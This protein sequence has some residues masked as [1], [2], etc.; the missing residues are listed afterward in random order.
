MW[1][2]VVGQTRTTILL[3]GAWSRSAQA[4]LQDWLLTQYRGLPV[5]LRAAPLFADN[6]GVLGVVW[7][8]GEQTPAF[9]TLLCSRRPRVRSIAA[10]LR[11]CLYF[12]R[13]GRAGGLPQQVARAGARGAL[14]PSCAK[15]APQLASRTSITFRK[16]LMSQYTTSS[17]GCQAQCRFSSA[18]RFRCLELNS[19]IRQCRALCWH[20]TSSVTA[21]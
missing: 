3:L 20:G 1:G 12:R 9:G 17:G 5:F 6:V 10:A 11:V 16:R 21:S 15:G 13:S 19:H 7:P 2:G 8:R 4:V 14:A 18:R